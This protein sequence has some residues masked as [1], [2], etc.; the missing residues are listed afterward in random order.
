M[1]TRPNF[2][3][4]CTDHWPAQLRR[5][6]GWSSLL[7]P[8]LDR[9]AKEG[10]EFSNMFSECP[11]CIPA[12]RSLMTGTT[13]KTHGDRVYSDRMPMPG[14]PTLASVFRDA[15]YQT[16]VVGK[17]HVYPQRDRIG[18]EESKIVEEAR[19]E[20][21][22]TDDYQLWLGE[23]GLVGQEFLHGMGSNTYHARPWHLDESTHPTSWIGREM[24]KQIARK[25]PTRPAFFYASFTAPHPPLVPPQV[26]LDMYQDQDMQEPYEGSWVDEDAYAIKALRHMGVQY[27]KREI[28]MARKAFAAL[29]TQIDHQIRTLIGTLREHQLLDN[30]IIGF[31]SDHGDMLFNHGMVAKRVFYQG[32]TNVPFLLAGK[33]LSQ[34]RGIHS[35]KLLCL[36]DV[37][38]TLLD[39]AG[40]EI[41]KTVEGL[42]AFSSQEREYV[43]GEIGEGDKASRMIVN[44]QYKLIYYPVGNHKQLFD[45]KNDP[46][47]LNNIAGNTEVA[48]IQKVMEQQLMNELYGDDLLWIE[49]GRLVGKPNKE[50]TP[51]SD[52]GLY[53]QRGIHWPT[54][55]SYGNLGANM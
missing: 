48:A 54:P 31:M 28:I 32:S 33:P 26:F 38:P 22:V 36:S 47:E 7:T 18:F 44:K 34:F 16:S 50:F 11:V 43:Y 29:C 8:T 27:S 53:N 42:S 25:D 1:D 17:L 37:M 10:V 9:L 35:D 52:L 19:Y 41:P 40:I 30:T 15:G 39:I 5:A 12:R 20:F 2:L 51:P 6:E 23:Q 21:G 46:K 24:A 4:I 55:K 45:L 49:N 14:L 3:L 13:P